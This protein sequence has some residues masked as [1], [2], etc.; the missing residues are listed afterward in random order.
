[1]RSVI[2]RRIPV[3]LYG[4]SVSYC[5]KRDRRGVEG[6]Y[7]N[8]FEFLWPGGKS[9]A[10]CRLFVFVVFGAFLKRGY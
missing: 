8:A 3:L 5:C 10:F 9:P 6:M 7:L 4:V 1:M 2:M